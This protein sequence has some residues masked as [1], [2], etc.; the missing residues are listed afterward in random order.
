M[1]ETTTTTFCRI[2]EALC[3]LEVTLEGDE[4]RAIRPD[5]SHVAT[6]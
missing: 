1:A 5:A 4:V 3:G 2:C 6:R